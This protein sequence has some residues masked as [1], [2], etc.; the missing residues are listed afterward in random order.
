M[1][2]AWLNP[3][4]II[5]TPRGEYCN[6]ACVRLRC[7]LPAI[8]LRLAGHQVVYLTDSVPGDADLLIVGKAI[9]DIEGQVRYA[10]SH[11]IPVLLDICD[12]I[13]EPPEDGLLDHYRK[14]LPFA[15]G[16]TVPTKALRTE[17]KLRMSNPVP[18]TVVPDA[19]ETLATAPCF[20]PL[21]GR[22]RLLWFG[23]PNGVLNLARALPD[24]ATLCEEFSVE[25][26]IITLAQL[27]L[28]EKI[29]ALAKGIK[30]TF[31]EWS[32]EA[33]DAG[34]ARCDVVVLPV[35]SKPADQVKSPN[36]LIAGLNAGKAVVAQPLPSYSSF[37][38]SAIICE[39][40]SEGIREA[41]A[42]VTWTNKRI[43]RGQEEIARDFD[44]QRVTDKWL[45]SIRLATG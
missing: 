6:R 21:V 8:G 28:T 36:R 30:V 15:R 31:S 14:L 19:V 1:K 9:N 10:N 32:Q 17:L 40:L 2:I 26:E 37:L 45:K 13:F 33:V 20:D 29:I 35:S 39:R 38:D 42:D 43:L 27:L 4:P 25:L 18:V 24:L 34:L 5:E 16:V 3:E 7:I 44:L 23:Y 11:A 22:I 12:H 41:T